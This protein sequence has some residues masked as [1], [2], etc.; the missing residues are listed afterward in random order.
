MAWSHA[1]QPKPLFL[2]AFAPCL[3]L[4]TY[5]SQTKKVTFVVQE[6]YKSL[7]NWDISKFINGA[8]S[9]ATQMLIVHQSMPFA[10]LALFKVSFHNFY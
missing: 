3:N 4:F 2:V 10:H 9:L 5:F 6:V 8:P 1:H 7:S